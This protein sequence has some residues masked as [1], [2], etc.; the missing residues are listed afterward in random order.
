MC[1]GHSFQLMLE[2]YLS[3]LLRQYN[4]AMATY[5]IKHFFCEATFPEMI[6]PV[7]ITMVKHG[8]IR[9]QQQRERGVEL[10][11]RGEGVGLGV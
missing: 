8:N 6:E 2:K 7:I 3:F 4:I 10:A 9:R 11:G 1:F 5:K